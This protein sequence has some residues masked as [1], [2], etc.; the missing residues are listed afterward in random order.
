MNKTINDMTTTTKES[1]S[2]EEEDAI[3]TLVIIIVA[4]IVAIIFLFSLGLFLDCKHQESESLNK[5]RLKLKLPNRMKKRGPQKQEDSK[6]LA[7]EMCPTGTS[8]LGY[9]M[10]DAVV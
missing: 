8:E 7:N 1:N 10:S 9:N 2:P 3:V 4:I 5:K 6:S